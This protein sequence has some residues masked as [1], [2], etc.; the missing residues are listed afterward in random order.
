MK[1]GCNVTSSVVFDIG[2]SFP[3]GGGGGGLECVC[4]HCAGRPGWVGRS[5]SAG[6][7]ARTV[8]GTSRIP[9]TLTR[10]TQTQCG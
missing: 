2:V 10:H 9:E 4:V 8:T 7:S 1:N 6:L 3:A 5:G